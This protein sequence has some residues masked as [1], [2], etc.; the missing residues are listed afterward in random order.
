MIYIKKLF[1]IMCL[2]N[3]EEPINGAEQ[4]DPTITFGETRTR[5]ASDY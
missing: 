5:V 4:L 3:D 1:N 2:H